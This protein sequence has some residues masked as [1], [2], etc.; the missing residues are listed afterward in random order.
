LSKEGLVVEIQNGE[1][2]AEYKGKL[3]VSTKVQDYNIACDKWTHLTFTYRKK[4]NKLSVF[5]NCDEIV[6]FQLALAEDISL[7]GDL[8]FGNCNLDAELTEIRIWKEEMPIKLIK[9]NY[10]S[11]LPILAENKRKIRMKINKQDEG[12]AKKKFEFNKSNLSGSHN[13]KFNYNIRT[14]VVCL[15]K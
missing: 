10:K 4:K 5:L 7:K 9:E 15:R 8:F 1:L 2:V 6:N 12:Q 3:L 14:A 11:P 13:S